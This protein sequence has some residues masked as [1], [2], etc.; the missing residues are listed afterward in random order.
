[1]HLDLSDLNT[2]K[3]FAIDFHSKY[4]NLDLLINNAGLVSKS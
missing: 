4:E 3:K 2:V 1:M